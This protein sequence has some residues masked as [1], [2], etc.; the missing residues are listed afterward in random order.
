MQL[1]EEQMGRPRK[2]KQS[3]PRKQKPLDLMKQQA[4]N[5]RKLLARLSPDARNFARREFAKLGLYQ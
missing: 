3:P 1:R 4:E 5:R 2:T